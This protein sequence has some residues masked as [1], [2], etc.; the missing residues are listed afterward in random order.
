M[1][2]KSAEF[3]DKIYFKFKDYS[4]EAQKIAEIIHQEHPLTKTILD[5]ACGTGEHAK[6]LHNTHGFEVEGIDLDNHL[7]LLARQ[8]NHHAEFVCADMVNFDL[9][10]TYDVMMCLFSSIGYLKTLDRVV[11]ALKRFKAHTTDDGL[12]LV[13]PWFS[14][15]ELTPGKIFT[16]NAQTN[17]LSVVRMEY[18]EVKDRMSTLHFEYLIG[19]EGGIEHETETHE[20]GL[21]TIE[22]THQCFKEAG[23]IADFDKKGISGRGLY[24]ARKE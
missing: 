11:S 10:K 18:S 15:G 13:E 16:N 1:F 23:L 19:T 2:S 12:I 21:F 4:A 24:I 8:K 6:I 9:G 7:I 5:V 3:Y 17:E 14:P 22:E 20:L